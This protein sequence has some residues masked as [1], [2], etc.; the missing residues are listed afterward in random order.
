MGRKQSQRRALIVQWFERY[1][2]KED[3]QLV[4]RCASCGR[5]LTANRADY[6]H[7]IPAGRGG[8]RKGKVWSSNGIAS[9]RP[10]HD[11]L[12]RIGGEDARQHLIES[13]A[14]LDNDELVQW[15]EE[16]WKSLRAHLSRF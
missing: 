4:H 9:C 16:Q 15:T 8:D 3:D 11:W 2:F 6:S 5:P 12:E 10:C 7:K 13:T 14:S 1:G